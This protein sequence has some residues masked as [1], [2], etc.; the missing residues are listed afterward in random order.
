[1][2]PNVLVVYDGLATRISE[3][4]GFAGLPNC[5]GVRRGSERS[6]RP[7]R[8]EPSRPQGGVHIQSCYV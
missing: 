8:T 5:G 1:M 2:S 3:T 7:S 6:D 4:V